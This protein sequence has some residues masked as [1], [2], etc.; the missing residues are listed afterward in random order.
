MD[1][2]EEDPKMNLHTQLHQQVSSPKKKGGFITIPFI[3]ANES[4]EKVATYGL[5]PNMIIYLMKDYK[6]SVTKAQ[7]LLYFW[8]AALNFLPIVGAFLADSFLGRFLTIGLGS[9]LSLLGMI[10]LWMTTILP[11]VKPPPCNPTVPDSCQSPSAGQYAFLI[12][13]FILMSIGAGGVR[14]CSQ[15]FGADQMDQRD[16][17]KNKRVL[18]T[19]F[20]W[21]YACSCLSVVIALTVVVYIQ[22]HYGWRIGFGVP[23]ILMFL[24]A[25]SFFLASRWYLTMTIQSSLF[26]N[27]ARVVVAAFKNRKMSLS[28]QGSNV[29]YYQ[30]KDSSPSIPSDKLRF[31][32][33]A[34]IIQDPDQDVTPEGTP[35]YPW[36]LSTVE[37]VE[38][39][40]SLLRVIPIWSSA[41]MMSVTVSVGSFP[42]LLVMTMDRHLGPKFEI[43]AASF[44]TFLVIVIVIWIPI[45]DRALLPL[46]SKICGKPVRLGVKL[47]MGIGLF[48]SFLAMVV[49]AIVESIRREKAISQ[50][51]ETNPMAMIHMSALWTIPQYVFGGLAEAFNGIGQT[52]FYYSELPKSMSSIATCLSG[53]GMAFGSLIASLILNVVNGITENH[54]KQG[55]IASNVN[56]GHYDYYYWLLAIL[57][58]LNILYYA[59]CSRAYGPV[60]EQRKS[61]LPKEIKEEELAMLRN[62]SR[63]E[64]G[65]LQDNMKV[66]K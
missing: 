36:R 23:V 26:I 25:F 59:F 46:A 18:E 8:N 15:A 64:K 58:F 40:K 61:G 57:S 22:D 54:G 49:A 28:S 45:Y 37:D 50:G 30:T 13:A 3:I 63:H 11:K 41:I 48:C 10:I 20:N 5:I 29:Q 21:Y 33:K 16:N 14:P 6:M 35:R 24:S 2:S 9:L 31:L 17:P 60:A 43:P 55:W 32:N 38:G 56:Q 62:T 27:L 7:N 1:T 12:L 51:F 65:E 42:V 39:L 47:R 4:F 52:E 53:V 34:C 44:G 66:L 19:F